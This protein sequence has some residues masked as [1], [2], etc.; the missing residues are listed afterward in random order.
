[1][2]CPL[3]HVLASRNIQNQNMTAKRRPAPKSS[4]G[5]KF[6]NL[7][8][9]E[10]IGAMV[11]KGTRSTGKA[12]RVSKPAV[13]GKATKTTA[14]P[15]GKGKKPSAK[16]VKTALKGGYIKPAEAAGLNPLGGLTPKSKDVKSALGK[17]HISFDEAKALN[18][19]SVKKN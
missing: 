17:G 9:A 11:S 8:A 1:M 15:A 4:G 7:Q 18:P 6:T 13:K 16:N 19:R 3:Q 5:G 10:A 2:S 12:G 14:V